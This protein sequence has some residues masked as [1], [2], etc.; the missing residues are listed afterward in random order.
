MWVCSVS[1]METQSGRRP[2]PRSLILF[3][4]MQI[5]RDA[6]TEC[7]SKME[8][9]WREILW[10]YRLLCISTPLRCSMWC[11]WFIV[12]TLMILIIK[13]VTFNTFLEHQTCSTIDGRPGPARPHWWLC[14]PLT[15][16]DHTA[17]QWQSHTFFP[18]TCALLSDWLCL[19][20]FI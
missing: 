18:S 11:S 17:S 5:C 19:S 2:S 7:F 6:T 1:F 13:G 15:N 8:Y 9:N 16:S 20:P 12:I 14:N 3:Y 10:G 4:D